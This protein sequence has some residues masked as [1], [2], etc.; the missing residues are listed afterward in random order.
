MHFVYILQS[1]K[2]KGLYIGKT[3]NLKRR[4]A[5]HKGGHVSSTKSRRPFRLVD[6]ISCENEIEARSLEHKL[7]SGSSREELKKK[8]NL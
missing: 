6:T 5:E 1:L 3:S 7:K 8:Y 2:D 4:L